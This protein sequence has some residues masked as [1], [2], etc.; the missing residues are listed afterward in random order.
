MRG[1]E[2]GKRLYKAKTSLAKKKTQLPS[3]NVLAEGAYGITRRNRMKT[4]L[5]KAKTPFKKNGAR[6][7]KKAFT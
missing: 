1:S 3:E 5:G 6:K 7:G 2:R 4:W